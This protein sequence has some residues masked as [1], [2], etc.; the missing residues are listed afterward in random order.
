METKRCPR[1]DKTSGGRRSK[2]EYVHAVPRTQEN[3]SLI[4]KV[5]DGKVD[6]H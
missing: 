2:W 4:Y 3:E 6:K 1:D 5:S